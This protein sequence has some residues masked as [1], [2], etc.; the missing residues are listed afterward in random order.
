MPLRWRLALLFAFGTV[1]VVALAGVA[2]VWQ[3][4][5]SLNRA[6]DDALS[7]R[8]H[9]L[10][11]AIATAKPLASR[12]QGNNQQGGNQGQFPGADEFTQVL[13]PSGA[14][15][16]YP[17]ATGGED[18][19]LADAQLRRAA[20]ATVLLTTAIEGQQ[21]RLLAMPA[22]NGGRRVIVLVGTTTS[23]PQTAESQAWTAILTAAPVAAVVAGLP[24]SVLTGAA[25]HPGEPMRR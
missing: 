8:A 6:Q 19:L 14:L 21:V 9:A 17:Q 23:I 20:T 15:L 25:L 4:R 7:A 3:L 16:D 12:S 1:A 18:P 2:F 5:V 22:R 11:D 13:T 24:A 10:A